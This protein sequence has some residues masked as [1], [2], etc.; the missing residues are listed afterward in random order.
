MR[1]RDFLNAALATALFALPGRAAAFGD[2]SRLVFVMGRHGGRWDARAAGLRRLAYEI[3][4]RTSI[5]TVQEPKA[6]ALDSKELFL[7]PFLYLCGDGDF[8]LAEAEVENLRRYVNY[9][10]FVLCDGID[11][12]AAA[13]ADACERELAR[14]LTGST[15]GRIPAD[16]VLFKSFYLIDQPAGRTLERPYLSGFVQGPR[17]AAVISAN[18]LAGAWARDELGSWEYEVQ[19]GGE[20][21]REVAFRLGVN[22]N[23]YAMCTDYKEDQVHIPFIMKRRR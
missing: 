2:T 10:G 7:H 16:H 5:A 19:P 17:L 11:G 21:Q 3:G 20:S 8:R 9:G 15:A 13:F 18:D 1:R 23:M 4:L 12:G 6:L 22:I 14:V